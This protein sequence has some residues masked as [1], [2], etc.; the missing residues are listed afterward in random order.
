MGAFFSFS[1]VRKRLNQSKQSMILLFLFFVFTSI[2]IAYGWIAYGTTYWCEHNRINNPVVTSKPDHLDCYFYEKNQTSGEETWTWEE[3]HRD[4]DTRNNNNMLVAYGSIAV[5]I[6]YVGIWF[7]MTYNSISNVDV[8][9]GALRKRPGVF[10]VLGLVSLAAAILLNIG[11]N[12]Y[13]NPCQWSRTGL[14]LSE[15]QECL[16]SEGLH[17]ESARKTGED[18]IFAGV[19]TLSALPILHLGS[20]IIAMCN[21]D[22]NPDSIA[23]DE[24]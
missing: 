12:H 14:F 10:F 20:W 24:R 21:G 8:I 17:D 7:T 16:T 13:Q 2:L 23:K 3:E 18:L 11:V 5:M 4:Y 22:D 15:N 1:G 6:V 9:V 19:V